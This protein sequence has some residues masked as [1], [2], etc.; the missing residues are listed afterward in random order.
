MTESTSL[1]VAVDPPSEAPLALRE[2]DSA[3]SIVAIGKED[4]APARERLLA[5]LQAHFD[6]QRALAVDLRENIAIAKRNKW[7]ASGLQRALRIADRMATFYDNAHVAVEAGYLLAP[8]LQADV[9]AVRKSSTEPCDLPAE[10]HSDFYWR[11]ATPLVSADP[12]IPAGEGEYVSDVPV[13]NRYSQKWKDDKGEH[14]RQV[15]DPTAFQPPEALLI[16][17]RPKLMEAAE[18]AMALKVFD[19]VGIVGATRR[20]RRGDPLLVGR[21]IHPTKPGDGDLSFFLAWFF[22]PRSLR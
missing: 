4:F 3:V 18:R 19:E 13:V 14:T 10:A 9:F 21:I 15:V 6:E 8:N 17:A 11:L 22:D 12:S 20:S 5:L 1:V 16:L 7:R 2:I